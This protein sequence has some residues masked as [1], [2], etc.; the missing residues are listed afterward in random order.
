MNNFDRVL[1]RLLA[2]AVLCAPVGA[3]GSIARYGELT[4]G[5]WGFLAV[6]LGVTVYLSTSLW[7]WSKREK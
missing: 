1:V 5:S 7:R 4:A 6:V 2:L 3:F